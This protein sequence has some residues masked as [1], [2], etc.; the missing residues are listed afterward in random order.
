M[1]NLNFRVLLGILAVSLVFASCNKEEEEPSDHLTVDGT[2]Y[3]LSKGS[4]KYYGMYNTDP[5]SYNFDIFLMASTVTKST[6]GSADGGTGIAIY[7]EMYS[8]SATDLLPGTYTFDSAG[9][10][11][12]LTFDYA[13][14][15][16]DISTDSWIE[17]TAG[18]VKVE[19]S[20][21]IYKLTVDGTDSNGKKVSGYYSGTL[22]Y[23]DRTQ[24]MKSL[25][26]KRR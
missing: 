10:Q 8:S 1:K 18:T 23:F 25:D 14:Y 20:E 21:S 5:A 22:E 9:S 7:F 12:A 24:E 11:N 13:D 4:I 3:S 26:K 2:E 17:L 6:V 15:V 16:L 19:K